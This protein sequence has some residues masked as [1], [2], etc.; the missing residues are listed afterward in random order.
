MGR[1]DRTIRIGSGDLVLGELGSRV[2]Q[3]QTERK[4]VERPPRSLQLTAAAARRPQIGSEGEVA[5]TTEVQARLDPGPVDLI[6]V[7]LIRKA[8]VVGTTLHT[9]LVA[10]QA[11]RVITRRNIGSTEQS[12]GSDALGPSKRYD[13]IGTAFAKSLCHRNVRHCVW[14]DVVRYGALR[15]TDAMLAAAHIT[16]RSTAIENSVGHAKCRA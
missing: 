13:R 3:I 16:D 6:N 2:A 7:R 12:Q 1:D 4:T 14:S 15:R 5:T 8:L 10:R 11:V 9:E